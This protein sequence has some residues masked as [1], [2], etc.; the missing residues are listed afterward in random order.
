MA[1]HIHNPFLV[2]GLPT[3]YLACELTW[4]TNG[5][6][7]GSS[8]HM[9]VVL[10]RWLWREQPRPARL[11]LTSAPSSP[12]SAGL[13]YRL[14]GHSKLPGQTILAVRLVP[15]REPGHLGTL[16]AWWLPAA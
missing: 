11:D 10:V 6:S 3:L 16:M 8:S 14:R 9:E 12:P 5:Q 7:M 1:Y 13:G 15:A 4:D 2:D